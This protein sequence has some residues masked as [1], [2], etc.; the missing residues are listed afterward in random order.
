MPM[1]RNP[2]VLSMISRAISFSFFTSMKPRGRVISRPMKK[3]R[4]STCFS[5]SDL[6]W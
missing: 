2:I 6:S 1:P 3:L 4:H 5:P